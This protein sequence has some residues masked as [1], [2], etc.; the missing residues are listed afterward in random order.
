M[1]GSALA[2]CAVA[3]SISIRFGSPHFFCAA[4]SCSREDEILPPLGRARTMLPTFHLAWLF[5]QD[6]LWDSGFDPHYGEWLGHVSIHVEC[7]HARCA[8]VV[9]HLIEEIANA[10]AADRG[11]RGRGERAADETHDIVSLRREKLGLFSE[12]G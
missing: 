7:D 6:G 11:A 10:R 9:S 12:F 2:F 5:D 1:S 4:W 3:G 8:W